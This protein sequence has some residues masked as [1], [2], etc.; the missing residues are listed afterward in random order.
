[1]L[2]LQLIPNIS[3]IHRRTDNS[4]LFGIKSSVCSCD[5]PS[6]EETRRRH[7]PFIR[8]LECTKCG[9]PLS[10]TEDREEAPAEHFRRLLDSPGFS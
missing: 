4:S 1:M 5:R 6:G 9:E 2:L 10:V 8:H 3:N 7:E